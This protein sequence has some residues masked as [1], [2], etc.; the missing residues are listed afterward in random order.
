MTAND[1]SELPRAYE[2]ERREGQSRE[3]HE[4]RAD[5]PVPSGAD[6]RRRHGARYRVTAA[7]NIRC[8]DERSHRLDT[9]LHARAQSGGMVDR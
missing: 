6:D 5:H 3:D 8:D 2:G 7:S 1:T 4:R 9:P